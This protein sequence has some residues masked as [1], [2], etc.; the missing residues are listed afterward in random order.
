[1]KGNKSYRKKGFTLIELMVAMAILSILVG[2]AAFTYVSQLT[3]IHLRNDAREV[4]QALQLAK[5][6]ALAT[7]KDHGVVFDL[8]STDGDFYYIFIDCAGAGAGN[9]LPDKAYS[10]NNFDNNAP[11]GTWNNCESAAYD[12]RI[13]DKGMFQTHENDHIEFDPDADPSTSNNIST[14]LQYIA[15]NHLG[16]AHQG[17]NLTSIAI[18]VKSKP[19]KNGRQEEITIRITGGTGLTDILPV[20]ITL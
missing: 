19:G 17:G 11:V 20:R 6:R 10:F 1:M 15:F 3:A 8:D 12:P 13:T 4:D 9:K 18:V 7:G 16:Q 2:M 5:M 14:G